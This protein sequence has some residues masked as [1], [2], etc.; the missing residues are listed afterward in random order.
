M[1]GCRWQ[2][3]SAVGAIESATLEVRNNLAEGSISADIYRNAKLVATEAEVVPG[4]G[5]RPKP[6][7]EDHLKTGQR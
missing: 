5:D 3:V 6:A 1:P 2:L 4:L 7:M